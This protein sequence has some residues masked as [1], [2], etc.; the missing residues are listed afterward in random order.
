MARS[1]K[2]LYLSYSGADFEVFRRAGATRCT[3]GVK[4]G[5]EEGTGVMGVL[6]RCGLV[7]PQISAPTRGETVR[8]TPKSFRGARRCSRS[9]I[10]C[11]VWWGLISSFHI[12][13]SLD[14]WVP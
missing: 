10:T 9:S 8:Q 14:A 7:T 1:T 5:M 2:R 12:S 13:W 4:F 11:Q 3:D 6:S